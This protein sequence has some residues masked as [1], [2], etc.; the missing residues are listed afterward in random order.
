MSRTERKF[1]PELGEEAQVHEFVRNHPAVRLE[2]TTGNLCLNQLLL[3][4]LLQKTQLKSKA[5]TVPG[6]VWGE[7]GARRGTAARGLPSV[8]R[9][10]MAPL[11]KMAARR[12]PREAKPGEFWQENK[13]VDTGWALRTGGCLPTWALEEISKSVWQGKKHGKKIQR[14]WPTE[15][16]SEIKNRRKAGSH[17]RTRC[18]Q[19]ESEARGRKQ[20]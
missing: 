4:L 9:K 1:Y 19:L 15:E 3:L 13:H 6:R 16:G 14:S 7:S 2:F 18:I 11:K 8:T 5:W 12:T 10:H 20:S 17:T